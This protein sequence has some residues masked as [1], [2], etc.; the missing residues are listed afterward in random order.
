MFIPRT[1][2]HT[3][4]DPLRNAFLCATASLLSIPE[5]YQE[6]LA[7]LETTIDP[8]CQKRTYEVLRFGDNRHLGINKVVC[9]FAFVGVTAEEAE[10]W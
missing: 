6:T 7:Q 9:F 1:K 5:L 3:Y 8:E 10:L 2:G 4:C